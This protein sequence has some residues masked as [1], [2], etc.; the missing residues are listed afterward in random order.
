[1]NK[2]NYKPFEK[3]VMRTPLLSLNFY[4]DLTKETVISDNT[5]KELIAHP[6]IR[7]AI[8]LASPS[9]LADLDDWINNLKKN[10]DKIEKLKYTLLKYLSRMSSRCTPYGLFASCSIGIIS[11]ETEIQLDDPS[12]YRRHT[13][14]DMNF[15]VSYYYELLKT[16]EIKNALKLY[17]NSSLFKIADKYRYV[18]YHY[19]NGNR[20][21]EIVAVDHSEYLE[22]ILSTSRNGATKNSLIKV[23]TDLGFED[24]ESEEFID[25]IILNQILVFELEPNVTGEEYQHQ[26]I[27][28]LEKNNLAHADTLKRIL[29]DINTL[30][31]HIGNPTEKYNDIKKLIETFEVPFDIKNLFQCDLIST[32]K[33][34]YLEQKIVEQL[35]PAIKLLNKI[36]IER[37]KSYLN[38]F[39]EMFYERYEN[40]EIPLMVALDPEIGIGYGSKVESDDFNPLIDNLP[41]R[42]KHSGT[43][44]DLKWS[45]ID[46]IFQEKFSLAIKNNELIVIITDDDFKNIDIASD[47]NL[48]PTISVI[49]EIVKEKADYKISFTG[50]GGSSA[51]NLMARFCHSDDLINK[52][53]SDIISF[54]KL[55]SNSI[56]AEIVHLPE[57]RVGNI[58]ARPSF[59]DFEI[60]YLAKSTKDTDHQISIEDLTISIKNDRLFLRHSKLN[61][62]II[63]RLTNAHNFSNPRAL[64]VYHFLCD[65]QFNSQ[66]RGGGLPL[67]SFE[68]LYSFF[69]RIEYKNI[70]LSPTTWFMKNSDIEHLLKIT[71]DAELLTAVK[72]LRERFSFPEY[73]LLSE[74]DNEL[75]INLTNVTSVK[76][77]LFTVKNRS[78][79]KLME[80]LHNFDDSIVNDLSG[81]CYS[82]EFIVSFKVE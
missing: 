42:S 35:I 66:N 30:D 16:D 58:L 65:M 63:P 40:M 25:E 17:P 81:N 74:G 79:F 28:I 9:F 78:T 7:E 14:L 55:K 77:L 5:F 47:D 1:M 60:P 29:N 24:Q 3:Y 20:M 27:S 43:I 37:H 36:S 57:S 70:I 19:K 54:E 34:N 76:M 56:I 72:I 45:L 23:L 69:P 46:D 22:K 13:R 4:K 67:M 26:L 68:S 49:A 10:E 52:H 32:S 31:H 48:P 50:W 15:M 73:I 51:A 8:F 62:E 75:L 38:K 71:D 12:Q 44:Q 59:R 11:S 18:E 2:K 6:T 39:K 82:N 61:K 41:I 21:Y 80:F 64:P 33:K 53:V